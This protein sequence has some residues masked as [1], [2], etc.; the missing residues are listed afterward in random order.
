MRAFTGPD[1]LGIYLSGGSNNADPA[2]S[3]GGAP[4]ETEVRALGALVTKGTGLVVENVTAAN[5]EGEGTIRKL[6][7]G[8]FAYTP[9][10]A[11]E[12]SPAA[13][14][15]D[16]RVV[17]RGADLNKAVRV[18][19]PRAASADGETRFTLM[20]PYNGVFGMEDVSDAD[21]QSGAVHYRGV[22]LVAHGENSVVNGRVWQ[23]P[24]DWLQGDFSFGLETPVAG[25]IQT[26]ADEDTAPSG[27]SFSSA[28]SEA[29]AIRL[30]DLGPGESVGFWVKREFPASGAMSRREG[31][32]L[33]FRYA[34][35]KT[36]VPFR[37]VPARRVY[38]RDIVLQAGQILRR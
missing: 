20:R 2:A 24:V 10:G 23:T 17:L 28:D 29:G 7:D 33:N 19:R 9:P 36:R 22:L 13:L 26:I 21:R 31:I 38:V 18:Y 37:L 4:S 30:P 1:A 6:A 34:E 32:I 12:G 35:A 16:S 3:L 11:T 5:G 14:G 25:E 8:T 15:P 27:V